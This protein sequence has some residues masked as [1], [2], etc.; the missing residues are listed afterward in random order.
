MEIV[1][2]VIKYTFV[3]ALGV[4]AILMVRAVVNLVREKARQPAPPAT[5]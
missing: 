1:M 5:E 4:E 2:Y 3:L